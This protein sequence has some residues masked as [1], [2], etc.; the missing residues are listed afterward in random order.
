[1][2]K[3]KEKPRVRFCWYCGKK[4]RANYFS[5]KVVDRHKRIFH[6]SCLKTA[7]LAIENQG[8]EDYPAND[9]GML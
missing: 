3:K 6:K 4:L 5:E 9:G 2:K 7:E 8:V 1:M